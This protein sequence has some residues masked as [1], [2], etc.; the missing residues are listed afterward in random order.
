MSVRVMSWLWEHSG[1]RGADLLTLLAIGDCADDTGSNAWPSMSTLATKTRQDRRTVQRIIRRLAD[2]G[3]LAVDENAG[4]RGVNR[5]R[6]LMASSKGRQSAAPQPDSQGAAD[7][8]GRQSAGAASDAKRGGTSAARTVLNRPIPPT[9]TADAAGEPCRKHAKTGK[10]GLNC[11]HCGT[12]ARI[13]AEAAEAEAR[14][15]PER[16][17]QCDQH[18]MVELA[19]GRMSRCPRC[20]PLAVAS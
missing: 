15:L 1:A 6:V 12:T 19:D 9:P 5:Y 11:R 3:Q 17:G 4:P 7:C 10:P 8:Q 20:H 2:S 13:M 14:R 18:R 16:C